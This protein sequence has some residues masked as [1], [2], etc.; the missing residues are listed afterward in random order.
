MIVGHYDYYRRTM[1]E[2][3]LY[4]EEALK[5]QHMILAMNKVRYGEENDI[6]NLV[7]YVNNQTSR[8]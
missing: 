6:H 8:I 7:E 3:T 4:K 5:R 2:E 1:L